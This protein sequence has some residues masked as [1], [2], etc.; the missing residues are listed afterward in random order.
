MDRIVIMHS[1][2]T[3][4]VPE[5]SIVL[6]SSQFSAGTGKFRSTSQMPVATNSAGRSRSIAAATTALQ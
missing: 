1:D 4:M 5:I 6:D 2:G 3:A